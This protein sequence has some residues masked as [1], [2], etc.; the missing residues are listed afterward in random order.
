M[1]KVAYS[2]DISA[3]SSPCLMFSYW[4]LEDV[5]S[6][7]S[8]GMYRRYSFSLDSSINFNCVLVLPYIQCP[9]PYSSL[10]LPTE[11]PTHL[12]STRQSCNNQVGYH[13]ISA[14]S[15]TVSFNSLR[16]HPWPRA[17]QLHVQLRTQ[18]LQP[19]VA[20]GEGGKEEG[21][22]RKKPAIMMVVEE[23]GPSV[24][25]NVWMLWRCSCMQA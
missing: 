12:R 25:H 3:Q 15:D 9:Y 5:H 13:T 8:I 4:V 22:R 23:P 24:I 20:Q 11:V 14:R 10:Q 16:L 2:R 6:E 17:L 19:D 18:Q 7:V 21:A 1:L